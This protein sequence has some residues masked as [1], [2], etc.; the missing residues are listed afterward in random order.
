[1]NQSF[2]QAPDFR[3]LFIFGAGGS[4][5]EVAWLATQAWDDAVDVRFLVD[6]QKYLRSAVNGHPVSLIS[7][8]ARTNNARYLIALGSPS[9]RE[10][11]ASKCESIGLQPATL[12]HPNVQMSTWVELG[13][14]TVIY[15]N[16]VITCNIRIGNHVQINLATTVSHDSVIGD[17]TTLS[18][19][20]HVSG[21]VHVGKRVFVGTNACIINGQPDAPL[22]IGDD[23][24]IAAGA[25]VTQHVESGSLVAGVPAVRKR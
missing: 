12:V 8:L 7:E 23:A 6:D 4:G 21:N 24:V 10:K 16:C 19:G 5:R 18:P 2:I 1:M 13:V 14:G 25:C 22:V 17:Y 15:A 3:E 9:L 11:L 20:V